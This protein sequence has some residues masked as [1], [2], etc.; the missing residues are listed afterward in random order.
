L[1]SADIS[2]TAEMMTM[3]GGGPTFAPLKTGCSPRYI[4]PATFSIYWLNLAESCFCT[5]NTQL[6]VPEVQNVFAPIAEC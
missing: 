5:C 3:M 2:S 4:L 1:A 6:N